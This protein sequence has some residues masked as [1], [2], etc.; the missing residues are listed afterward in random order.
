MKSWRTSLIGSL[1]IGLSI[2]QASGKPSIQSAVKDPMV[3]ISMLTGILGWLSKD[4][5][6]TT[7]TTATTKANDITTAK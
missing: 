2:I 1:F 6:V 7:A 5:Q 4:Q 3:Q